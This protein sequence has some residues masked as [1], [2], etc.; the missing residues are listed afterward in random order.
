[1]LFRRRCAFSIEVNLEKCTASTLYLTASNFKFPFPHSVQVD[2]K[3][4]KLLG[5]CARQPS[6]SADSFP[7][8]QV[9]T[10]QPGNLIILVNKAGLRYSRRKY[11]Q[12]SQDKFLGSNI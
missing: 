1:L 3:A 4:Y 10:D 9:R 12:G 7:D 11:N 2:Q 5:K 8:C 6:I